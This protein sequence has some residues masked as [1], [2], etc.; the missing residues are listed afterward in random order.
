MVLVKAPSERSFN[1]IHKGK[2][3]WQDLLRDFAKLSRL[4]DANGYISLFDQLCTSAD[5]G[6]GETV[7]G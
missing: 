6:V 3:T 2:I 5:V 4:T 1:L 7:V